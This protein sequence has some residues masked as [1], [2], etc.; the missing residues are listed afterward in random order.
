MNNDIKGARIKFRTF[1]VSN[2][3]FAADVEVSTTP[4]L[5]EQEYGAINFALWKSIGSEFMVKSNINNWIKCSAASSGKIWI[6]S[7]LNFVP[8]AQLDLL[9]SY[10]TFCY[11]MALHM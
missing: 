8:S 4:P 3:K 11:S 7:I 6:Y 2:I 5:G 9:A 10:V 1:L